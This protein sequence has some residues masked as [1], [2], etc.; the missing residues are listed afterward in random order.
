LYGWRAR[1]GVL[2]L[3]SDPVPECDLYKMAPEGI[4][5][6]FS[7]MREKG[8]VTIETLKKLSNEVEN[9]AELLRLLEPNVV[10]F[11][12]TSGSFIGGI[13]YDREIMKRIERKVP[14]SVATTTT[15]AIV[16]ALKKFEAKNISIA[17][18]YTREI[19]KVAKDFFEKQGFRV[20]EI[21]GLDLTTGMSKQPTSV[22]YSLSKSVFKP[23]TDSIVI[24][25]TALQALD[26]IEP[27]ERDLEVPVITSNQATMWNALRRAGVN[28][29]INGFG[30][31]FE[32]Y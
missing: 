14:C 9:A 11:C 23:G 22:I 29:R 28:E 8:E 10:A 31:L 7:R 24:S 5:L 18:P 15:T 16:E 1:I 21:K 25:C 27:L 19:N 32:R 20:K 4:S 17:T 2:V 12:C 30:Q 6:H 3:A 26:I 13:G